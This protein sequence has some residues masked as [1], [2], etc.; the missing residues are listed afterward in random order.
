M[1]SAHVRSSQSPRQTSR[2]RGRGWKGRCRGTY[3]AEAVEIAAVYRVEVYAFKPLTQV[4]KL[5]VAPGREVAV[6][7]SV[8]HTKEI[9]LCFR[10]PDQENFG[11]HG[12]SFFVIVLWILYRTCQHLARKMIFVPRLFFALPGHTRDVREEA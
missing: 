8:G 12:K 10:M 5:A 1:S 6:I 11:D 3:R 4:V 7:L 9:A 2:S